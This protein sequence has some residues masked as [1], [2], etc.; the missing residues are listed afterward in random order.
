[1]LR[2]D[3]QQ[4]EGVAQPSQHAGHEAERSVHERAELLWSLVGVREVAR[5][6]LEQ[7]S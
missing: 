7:R 4:R 5:E 2:A 6:G 3:W 1:M